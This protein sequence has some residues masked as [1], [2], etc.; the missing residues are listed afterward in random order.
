MEILAGHEA[1]SNVSQFLSYKEVG[2]LLSVCKWIREDLIRPELIKRICVD[3]E[4]RVHA[5][6]GIVGGA[7]P[8]N[9]YA[10]S[11]FSPPL[12]W[13]QAFPGL[14]KWALTR[15]VV[16]TNMVSV[17][18]Y[19]YK[20]TDDEF[21]ETCDVLESVDRVHSMDLY[22][23][24]LTTKMANRLLAI[25]HVHPNLASV[26]FFDCIVPNPQLFFPDF[27]SSNV[28][29]LAFGDRK[30]KACDMEAIV[31]EIAR[32]GP[33]REL[34]INGAQPSEKN[35]RAILDAL[36]VNTHRLK[37]LHMNKPLNMVKRAIYFQIRNK[38]RGRG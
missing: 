24:H 29:S 18:N 34:F 20:M 37:Y 26:H 35:L 33:L 38:L 30:L 32:D 12:A 14:Y 2:K 21:F 17:K 8:W 13:Y 19:M 25:V 7:L 4:K 9:T 10:S 36:D 28:R 6:W 5:R 16:R 22:R 3:H 31:A 15:D 27:G 11:P 23:V 1:L